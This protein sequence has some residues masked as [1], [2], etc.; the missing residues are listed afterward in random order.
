MWGQSIRGLAGTILAVVM[1]ITSFRICLAADRIVDGVPLP[2]DAAVASS[3]TALQRQ[4]AGTWVGAWDGSPK[5]IL[6]VETVAGDGSADV[7]YAIGSSFGIQPQWHR[8]KATL[9]GK[10][11][12]ISDGGLSVTYVANGRDAWRRLTSVEI[13]AA[14]QRWHDR[15][16]PR[17]LPRV[18]RTIGQERTLRNFSK[19]I[20]S[21]TTARS[22][23]KP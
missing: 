20:S 13:V 19:P 11:L 5:H 18:Q 17:S 21:R 1:V 14:R 22:V 8:H 7:I 12:S 15:T 2:S 3:A 10:S 4:W 6:V 16:W 9:S 23:S